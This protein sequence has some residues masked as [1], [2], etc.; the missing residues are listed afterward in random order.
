M[1]I[2]VPIGDEIHMTA[3]RTS[4]RELRA[5]PWCTAR[6][7]VAYGASVLSAPLPGDVFPFRILQ[8]LHDQNQQCL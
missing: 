3:P 2:K 6:A 1:S 8:Y 7:M 5:S 4:G